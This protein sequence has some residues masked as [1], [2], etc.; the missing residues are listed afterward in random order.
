M[1]VKTAFFRL[2]TLYSIREHLSE[3]VRK[4]LVEALVLSHFNYCD[5]VYEPRLYAKTARAIQRVQ[6]ACARFCY[7]VPKR[8]HITPFLNANNTLKMAARREL[9]LTTQ[10]YKI[11]QTQRPEYLFNKFI[12]PGNKNRGVRSMHANKV[13]MPGHRSMGFRGS[14]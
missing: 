12:W 6:N 1:L 13:I 7:N 10:L 4:L 5:I 14:F 9:H 11:I 8:A 2:K 3:N